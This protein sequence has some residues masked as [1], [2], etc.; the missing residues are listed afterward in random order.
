MDRKTIELQNLLR[1][2]SLPAAQVMRALDISKPTLSRLVRRSPGVLRVGRTRATRYAL[3]HEI[4]TFGAQWPLFRISR[5]GRAEHVADLH[6]LQAREWWYEIKGPRPDWLMGEY[7]WGIF[8]DL[9]WF[10]DDLRPQG[11]M[12]RAFAR[13]HAEELG[14]SLDPRLWD[15]AGVIEAL[16]L[17]GHDLPGDFVIGERAVTRFQQATLG[18]P[19]AVPSDKRRSRYGDLAVGALQ[20]EVP[21]SSAGG[22]QPKF[23][24]CVEASGTLRHVL[25]KFS[26]LADTPGGRRWADLLVCEHIAATALREHGVPACETEILEAGGRVFLEATRFDRVGAFGR[27]GFVSLLPLDATYYGKLDDWASAADRLERDGWLSIEDA[28]C[29]RLLW[30]FGRL[31]GNTDMHFANVG[32]FLDGRP[33]PLAPAYDMLPMFYRPEAGTEIVERQLAPLPPRPEQR[34]AWSKAATLAQL[35]WERASRDS[36]LSEPMRAEATRLVESIRRLLD[37]FG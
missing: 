35:F 22:E 26:P 12:G 4:R 5:D 36:R 2:G 25:V 17:Y 14:L 18:I 15:A 8:P 21:G 33:F 6:A 27:R 23:T 24:A 28:S 32:L 7:A 3:E 30:W 9:P 10:L 37:R 11:F 13:L 19:A 31:I 29:L 34:S 1:Q 16:L 20:G